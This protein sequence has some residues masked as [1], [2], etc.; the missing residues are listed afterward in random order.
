M[1]FDF[2][3]T[4]N[5]YCSNWVHTK[6]PESTENLVTFSLIKLCIHSCKYC[7]ILDRW[8]LTILFLFVSH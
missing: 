8:Q 2:Y 7:I 4:I 3:T 6:N 5:K 1:S